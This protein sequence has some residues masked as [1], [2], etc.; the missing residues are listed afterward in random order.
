[1]R[2]KDKLRTLFSIKRRAS[3]TK[4]TAAPVTL[5]N[6]L[7]QY[8]FGFNKTAYWPVHHSSVVS[9]IEHILIGK[10]TAPGLSNGCY[11]FAAQG[12]EI[13]IGDYTIIAPNV[14]I[15]GYNHD[16]KDFRQI[17]VKGPV[18]IGNYC[19]IGMNSVVL[20]GVKLGNHTIIAAGSVVTKSFEEG[21]L[22]L[23]GSPARAIRKLSESEVGEWDNKFPYYGYFNEKEFEVYKEQ[24]L[25]WK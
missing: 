12:G 2:I 6:F 1:M 16:L 25:N 20:P 24:F 13:V 18:H 7:I 22:V 8:L 3:Q 15:A 17:V 5:R 21:Y 14:C 23:A 19:W 9:G 4:G 10:G 11:I